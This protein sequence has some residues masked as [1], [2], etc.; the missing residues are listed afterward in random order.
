VTFSIGQGGEHALDVTGSGNPGIEHVLKLADEVG[1]SR[2]KAQE[3]IDRVRSATF[4]WPEFADVSG[5][6]KKSLAS[7]DLHLNGP[8]KPARRARPAGGGAVETGGRP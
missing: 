1:I 2:G 3:I 6:S 8:R 5:V 7:I 4:R